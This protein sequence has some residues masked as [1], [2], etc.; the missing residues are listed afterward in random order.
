MARSAIHR[1]STAFQHWL[2]SEECA[3]ST[4]RG[5]QHPARFFLSPS[6]LLALVF[7]L[8]LSSLAARHYPKMP[9]FRP[10]RNT[11]DAFAAMKV[12][13][14]AIQAC[15]DAYPALK[16]CISAA[17]VVV[18]MCEVCFEI[19]SSKARLTV[20][21]VQKIKSNKKGCARIAEHSARVVQDIWRQT[22]DLRLELPVEVK[23]S[24]SDIHRYVAALGCVAEG[25]EDSLG[26]QVIR[27]DPKFLR[28]AR[29][30]EPSTTRCS[31][32]S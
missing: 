26:S 25:F 9:L 7:C 10:T 14:N 2:T 4:P 20:L 24:V 30:G 27:R 18:E 1:N 19:L 22:T 8:L 32:R 21:P 11:S 3:A 13:L 17:I 6:L 16:S 5:I 12:T 23:E 15:T 29:T 31:T 28:G